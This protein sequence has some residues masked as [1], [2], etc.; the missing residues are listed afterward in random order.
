MEALVPLVIA[1]TG[2][3]ALVIAAWYARADDAHARGTALRWA[4]I[5]LSILAGATGLYFTGGDRAAGTAVVV[6]MVLAVNALVVSMVLHLRRG[7][8][9]R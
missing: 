8:R 2:M 6:A 9:E 5:A 7:G 4:L 3:P 1:L